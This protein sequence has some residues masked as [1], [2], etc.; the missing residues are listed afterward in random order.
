MEEQKCSDDVMKINGEE[1]SKQKKK[2]WQKV[3]I[4]II[5]AICVCGAVCFLNLNI[6]IPFISIPPLYYPTNEPGEV[7]T[8]T[9]SQIKEVFEISELQTADYVYNSITTVNDDKENVK[10][11]VAYE[12][13]VTAGI[14]FSAISPELNEE[15]KIITIVVPEVTIQ[16]AVV[17][18][19][20]LEYI[21]PNKKYDDENIYKEAYDRCQED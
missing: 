9:E 17:T 16:D 10:Y 1:I 21:F 6:S 14:D 7:K 20:S 13:K 8:I 2:K 11:Y 19:G 18:P 4:S 15:D 12:G 5:L 3:L